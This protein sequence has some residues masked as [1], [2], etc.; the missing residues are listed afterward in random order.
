MT[1]FHCSQEQLRNSCNL[2]WKKIPILHID[3]R[4]IKYIKD[5]IAI[6]RSLILCFYLL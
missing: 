2:F 5:D 1:K 3:C 4:E 6:I